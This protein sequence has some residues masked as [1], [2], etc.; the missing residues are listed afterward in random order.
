MAN[1]KSG[2]RQTTHN[3]SGNIKLKQLNLTSQRRSP[4]LVHQIAISDND[5]IVHL[6]NDRDNNQVYNGESTRMTDIF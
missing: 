5:E 1:D 4:G 6:R 2:F 3:E